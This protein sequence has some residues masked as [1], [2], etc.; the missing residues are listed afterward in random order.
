MRALPVLR[1]LADRHAVCVLAGGDAYAALIGEMPVIRI[2]NLRYHY[3]RAGSLSALK[4]LRRNVPMALDL[5]WNAAGCDMINDELAA[6]RAEVVISDGE[7][8]TL[9][10]AARAGIP[11]ISFDNF[12]ML[13]HCRLELGLVDLL[14]VAANAVGYR[15]LLGDADRILIASFFACEPKRRGV[16]VIGPIIRPEAAALAPSRGEHILAYIS[17]GESEYTPR[18]EEAFSQSG[19]PIHLYGTPRRGRTGNID[20]REMANLPFLEDLASCRAVMA[21]T[22]HQLLSEAVYFRKPVL[23]IPIDCIEQRVNAIEIERMGVGQMALRDS[24]DAPLLHG[25]LSRETEYA[26][27]FKATVSDG[28]GA[29][30]AAIEEFAAELLRDRA[31]TADSLNPAVPGA[32]TT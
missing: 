11:T 9:R 3:R 20:Y 15:M 5:L 19:L 31:A 21:T 32:V 26:A 29:A 10:A 25:F 14:R 8:F 2:P 6:H 28:V 24:I 23:G 17:K 7:P 1:R 13:A 22:G 4:T 27:N 18:L 30:I 16:R 12:G